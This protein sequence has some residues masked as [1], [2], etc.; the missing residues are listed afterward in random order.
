MIFDVWTILNPI[1]RTFIYFSVL[2]TIGTILFSL[3]FSN[4]FDNI[5]KVYCQN[6]IKKFSIFGFFIG[7]LV[8]LSV[9]G[10]LGG[11]FQSVIDISLIMLSFE[12]LSGKSAI[13]LTTGFILIIFSILNDK[14]F[15][16]L[17]K[18]LGILSILFSF[19]IIGHSTIKGIST[20]TLLILHIICISFW[21]GSFLPL[22]Y[23]CINKNFRNLIV[24]SE[25]FGFYAIFYVAILVIVGL[26]FSYILV[27]NMDG[28]FSTIY[29]NILL[30]KFIL[31]SILL[32]IGALN[33]LRLVPYL[34]IDYQVGKYKL[35]KSIEIEGIISLIILILTSI[36]TTSLPT[37]M[38]I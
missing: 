26:V 30:L 27:G 19:V 37:P 6:L 18:T 2:T 12:T 1:L 21:L 22:R 34:K 32:S 10:N 3:H 36:L 25:K 23:M 28:L 14:F 11:D 38:G 5:V 29:G 9:A 7:L 31:V 15:P 8:F 17:F 35:K 33:K 4:F 20:Q 16:V 24:I 13:L